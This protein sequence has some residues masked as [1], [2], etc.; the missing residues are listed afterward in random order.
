MDI[1]PVMKI[2]ITLLLQV[3]LQTTLP[4]VEVVFHGLQVLLTITDAL[5]LLMILGTLHMVVV[6]K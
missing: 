4:Q 3:Q 6:L 1:V 2:M 5:Y